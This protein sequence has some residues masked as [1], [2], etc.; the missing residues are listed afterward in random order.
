M[1]AGEYLGW[2]QRTTNSRI[3]KRIDQWLER[4]D[5]QGLDSR[6]F[7]RL[8]AITTEALQGGRRLSRKRAFDL[9]QSK[10]LA[11]KKGGSY[12]FVWALCQRK[13]TVLG[14]TGAG[15]EPDWGVCEWLGRRGST[16]RPWATT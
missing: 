4:G 10:G 15:G 12:E 11:P 5:F 6:E 9:W 3:L 13:V 1:I 16:H 7:E 14:P 8:Q 2:V